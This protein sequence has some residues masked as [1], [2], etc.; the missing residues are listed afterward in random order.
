MSAVSKRG[1]DVVLGSILAV[2]AAPLILMFAAAVSLSLRTW[3]FFCQERIGRGGRPFRIVKLRTLPKTSPR[4]TSK[5][6]LDPDSLPAVARYLRAAHLDELPQLLLV[7][8]GKMSLVGPRPEMEVLHH[9]LD[10]HFA[11]TRTRARPGCAGLWQ[12]TSAASGLIGESPEHDVCYLRNM[13]VRLDLWILWRSALL[14]TGLRPPC[15]LSDVPRWVSMDWSAIPAASAATSF[16]TR[17]GSD[18]PP[19]R[20]P[21]VSGRNAGSARLNRLGPAA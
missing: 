1:V 19:G 20:R 17:L 13:S 7:P 6:N 4:Y 14:M 16:D 5:Y 3:P 15:H 8:F 11:A 10:P 21:G 12:I 2:L 9:Q 18:D